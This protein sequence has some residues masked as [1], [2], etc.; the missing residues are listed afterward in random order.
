MQGQGSIPELCS[1]NPGDSNVDG[2]RLHVETVTG[3][4]VSMRAE[5]L[6]APGR[7]VTADD[8]NLKIGYI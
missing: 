2:H 4:A 5:E 7:A 8:I 3:H 6:V 1:R